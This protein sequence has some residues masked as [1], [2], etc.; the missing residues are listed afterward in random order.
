MCPVCNSTY[1]RFDTTSSNT[2]VVSQW[3]IT[4]DKKIESL[5]HKLDVAVKALELCSA[6]AGTADPGD[7]CRLVIQTVKDA[8][9]HIKSDSSPEVLEAYARIIERFGQ[10][11]RN[12]AKVD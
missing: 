5:Q 7:G 2:G 1:V 8:L 3:N 10:M 11:F 6:Q 9:A 4:D 12:L